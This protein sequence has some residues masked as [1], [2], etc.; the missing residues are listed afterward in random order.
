MFRA[1]AASVSAVATSLLIVPTA[2][3]MPPC[4]FASVVIRVWIAVSRPVPV[5]VP[6]FQ[7]PFV[8]TGLAKTVRSCS[9]VPM[10][11][12]MACLPG[13]VV[14]A[15]GSG[16]GPAGAGRSAGAAPKLAAAAETLPA[17]STA[18]TV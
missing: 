15:V 10:M 14:P 5:A 6:P 7:V 2:W 9:R 18:T 1:V 12:V 4:R 3:P 11:S 13:S 16:H 17:M 8:S